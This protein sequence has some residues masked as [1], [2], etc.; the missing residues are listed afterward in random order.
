[1]E[2]T[3]TWASMGSESVSFPNGISYSQ[4]AGTNLYDYDTTVIDRYVVTPLSVAQTQ[5]TCCTLRICG[6]QRVRF[7]L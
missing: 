6:M 1:M 4:R 7:D 3:G 2:V 5:N